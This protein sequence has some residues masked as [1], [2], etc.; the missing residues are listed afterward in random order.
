VGDRSD[1]EFNLCARLWEH[2]LTEEEIYAAMCLSPQEKWRDRDDTYRWATVRSAV[3]KAKS[4]AANPTEQGQERAP[5]DSICGKGK[6]ID[7][8]NARIPG[9]IEELHFKTVKDT[10]RLYRYDHGVYLDDGEVC[11]ESLIEKEFSECTN[12]KLIADAVGKVK[13]RTY[14]DRDAFNAGTTS[15]S[16]TDCW[17]WI[18]WSC[19]LTR[20]TIS[21][22]RRSA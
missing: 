6:A 18:L 4:G 5:E 22:R 10:G 17:T 2:G 3:E 1:R 13:R 19:D 16:E 14:I 11:L 21:P 12:N 9:W 7:L 15:T 20:R 8:I